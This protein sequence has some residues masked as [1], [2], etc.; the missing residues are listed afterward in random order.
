SELANDSG[1]AAGLELRYDVSVEPGFFTSLQPFVFFDSGKV[2]SYDPPRDGRSL[3][4][5]GAGLRATLQHGLSASLTAARPLTLS[6]SDAPGRH[7]VRFL[8]DLSVSF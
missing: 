1:W 2:W 3:S 4:S 5:T 6:P 7:P 8:F